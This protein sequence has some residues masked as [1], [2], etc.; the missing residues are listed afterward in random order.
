MTAI[1]ALIF[2]ISAPPAV[3]ARAATANY[4][5]ATAQTAY[6]F[7]EKDESSAIFIVPY[8]YC[9]TVLRDDGDWYYASYAQDA[10]IYKQVTGFC[11]KSDFSPL[12]DVPE[13]T[14]LYK[15]VTVTYRTESDNSTLPVPDGISIE[16]AFYGNFYSGASAYSY[17]YAQG[18]FGYIKGATEDFPLNETE[19]EKD[20][21][22]AAEAKDS[23]GGVNAALICA[24]VIC[25]LA[26]AALILLYFTAKRKNRTE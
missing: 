16:A 10:G 13:V 5:R 19:A 20:K 21:Q 3:P 9:V 14:Y 23:G 8:T 6:F 12:E 15:T 2:C 22:P 1:A 17:V 7:L 25:A 24:L 4:A 11:R 26:A 18:S